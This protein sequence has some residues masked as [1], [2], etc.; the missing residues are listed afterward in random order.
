MNISKGNIQNI[1]KGMETDFRSE[2]P[3]AIQL[4]EENEVKYYNDLHDFV[5]SNH[6]KYF[7]K[8]VDV[9]ERYDINVTFI[10][11]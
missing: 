10:N 2:N 8:Y 6:K 7:D 5:N 4:L 1:S 9:L 11:W 3:N